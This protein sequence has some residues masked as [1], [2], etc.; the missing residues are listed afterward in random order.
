MPELKVTLLE[1]I[2]KKVNFLKH[3]IR[4]L[5]LNNIEAIKGR[6][7]DEEI[8]KTYKNSFDCVISRALS[9]IKDYINLAKPYIKENGIILAMKG[10]VEKKLSS[11]LDEYQRLP[12]FQRGLGGL[13]TGNIPLN[14][15]R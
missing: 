12:L 14:C 2:E 3:I 8:I 11:E 9:S 13:N 6:A 1:A 15:T 10:P 4:T 7:E 5:G